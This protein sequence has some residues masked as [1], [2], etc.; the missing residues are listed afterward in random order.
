M[1]CVSQCYVYSKNADYKL[2]LKQIAFSYNLLYMCEGL[3]L[4]LPLVVT[5]RI[6]R[7]LTWGRKV[8]FLNK[9]MATATLP[10]FICPQVLTSSI[11]P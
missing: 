6:W 9:Q 1:S 10:F 8:F 2:Q 4:M 11:T 5:I 3:A 7:E